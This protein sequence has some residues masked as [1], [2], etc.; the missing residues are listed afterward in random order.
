MDE[1]TI[2]GEH[3]A[4]RNRGDRRRLYPVNGGKNFYLIGRLRK[5]ED[6][7][8]FLPSQKKTKSK[9]NVPCLAV[10]IFNDHCAEILLKET[11][12]EEFHRPEGRSVRSKKRGG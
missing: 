9:W 5:G 12:R 10:P 3:N 6:S 7:G 4:G 8:Q 2:L 11:K 1:G